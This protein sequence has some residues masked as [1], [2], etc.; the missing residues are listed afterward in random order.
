MLYPSRKRTLE[1][2]KLM[3]RPIVSLYRKSGNLLFLSGV[4]G[5]PGDAK[6]QVTNALQRLKKILEEA[7]TSMPNVLSAVIYLADLND[8]PSALNPLWEEYFPTDPPCR[9]TVEVGLGPGI[10]IEIQVVAQVLS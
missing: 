9:T 8:R 5:E 4:T 7:G 3:K 10:L 2:L 1:A 6:T